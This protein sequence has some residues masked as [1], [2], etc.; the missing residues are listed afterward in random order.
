MIRFLILSFFLETKGCI[1]CHSEIRKDYSESIHYKE[2]IECVSCHGG[3]EN[4][5]DIKRAHSDG[6]IGIPDKKK[7]IKVCASCHSLPQKMKP[8]GLPFDQEIMYYT[9]EHGEA[10]KKGNEEVAVCTDCHGVHKILPSK[11]PSSLTNRINLPLMCGRCHS[12]FNMM[13]KYKIS[14]DVVLEYNLSVHAEEMKRG[15]SNSPTCEDCHGTHGA[16]PPGIGDIEK[17]CG[18][19][20][21]KTREFYLK[22]YHSKIW[23]QLGYLEC[24]GCHSNHYVKRTSHDL[25]KKKCA[26]CHSPDSKN[27]KVAEE[28]YIL[29]ITAEME[30]KKTSE[31]IEILRKIP[32]YV[33]DFVSRLEEARSYL[34]EAEP[35]SH[36]L[37]IE[38][39]KSLLTKSISI[40]HEV[41]KEA[42]RRK[43]LFE[44]GKIFLPIFWFLIFFTIALI[45]YFRR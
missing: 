29:F 37:S 38:E 45:I 15:N 9:S 35:V 25:W 3:N 23:K 10:F 26:E 13:R 40:S 2:G 28:I 31:L 11:A 32:I 27:Y 14:S 21:I 42:I 39:I 16:V 1:I 19:C 7:I 4:T 22:S 6:F 34:I 20:H 30:I 12:D 18:K 43:K 8:Y 44:S 24:E 5:F 33:E 41:Q 36:S 17:V